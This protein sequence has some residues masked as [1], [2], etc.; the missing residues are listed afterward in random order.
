NVLL[1]VVLALFFSKGITG[2]LKVLS[3]NAALF[4]QRKELNK[5]LK[6][7]DEIAGLDKS[8]HEMAQ[9]LVNSE[10]RKQEFVSMISHDL[11]TPLTALQGTLALISQGS[12]G[13][14]SDKGK[15]RVTNAEVNVERLIKLINELLDIEKMEAGMLDLK[16]ERVEIASLI[17]K[18]VEAVR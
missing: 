2:R 5:P 13:Q 15:T 17:D 12:Y 18:S 1:T 14:L 9:A 8:F 16:K 6:G 3:E 11:R 10:K 7:A 4:A